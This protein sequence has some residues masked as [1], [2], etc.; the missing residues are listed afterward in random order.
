MGAHQIKDQHS[1]YDN[2]SKEEK[3]LIHKY[4]KG[5]GDK[6]YYWLEQNKSFHD[7]SLYEKMKSAGLSK[8]EIKENIDKIP[9]KTLV[10]KYGRI[11]GTPT[12]DDCSRWFAVYFGT[13]DFD[14]YSF[15]LGML[16]PTLQ[17][18]D[19]DS[20]GEF[21]FTNFSQVI[22]WRTMFQERLD[23]CLD[24]VKQ[25][26]GIYFYHDQLVLLED[27]PHNERKAL[28]SRLARIT[29]CI[30]LMGYSDL[31]KQ[32]KSLCIKMW[33]RYL[34]KHCSSEKDVLKSNVFGLLMLSRCGVNN[35]K[36]FES[37]K[38]NYVHLK[39]KVSEEKVQQLVNIINAEKGTQ[40][41]Y[42]LS[43]GNTLW[44]VVNDK[45]SPLD[46]IYVFDYQTKKIS[47]LKSDQD[48][49]SQPICW[50]NCVDQKQGL[51]EWLSETNQ[52]EPLV[53]IIS[54][55]KP[56]SQMVMESQLYKQ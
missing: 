18:L 41:S 40:E 19:N 38:H 10:M 31:F 4:A 13:K 47:E 23:F 12:F 15:V 21:Y 42:H 34:V 33:N 48:V 46:N 56:T 3:K 32:M 36:D 28:F 24:I 25:K 8:D 30:G 1:I 16:F 29:F 35:E 27:I 39:K 5:K 6:F 49:I 43:T 55:E 26:L 45:V 51:L 17:P 11:S 14:R 9:Y 54:K 50:K 2:N 20:W 52:I 53:V 22:Y 44:E 7:V 37:L